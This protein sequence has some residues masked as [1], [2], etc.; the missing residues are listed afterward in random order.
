MC[1]MHDVCAY[2]YTYISIQNEEMHACTYS[3]MHHALIIQEPCP[4][5]SGS[6]GWSRGLCGLLQG[7]AFEPLRDCE[8]WEPGATSAANS[9]HSRFNSASVKLFLPGYRSFFC[10]GM[11]PPIFSLDCHEDEVPI[12]KIRWAQFQQIGLRTGMFMS[13]FTEA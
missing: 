4:H 9:C 11:V 13:T 10:P 5:F 6:P 8:P 12:A 1:T 7:P 3:M 2:I